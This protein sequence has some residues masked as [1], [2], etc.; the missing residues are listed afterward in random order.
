MLKGGLYFLLLLPCQK[1]TTNIIIPTDFSSSSFSSKA[2]ENFSLA[3]PISN[4][5]KKINSVVL[6]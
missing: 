5:I 1:F 4:F 2:H 6:S 3:Y